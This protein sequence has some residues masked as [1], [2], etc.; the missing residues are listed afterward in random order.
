MQ[1]HHLGHHV[2]A[3]YRA[4][5]VASHIEGHYGCDVRG[6]PLA[7][8][9]RGTVAARR[10]DMQNLARG[11]SG[12]GGREKANRKSTERVPRNDR[13]RN[14]CGLALPT[15]SSTGRSPRWSPYAR[16]ARTHSEAQVEQIAASMRECG[17]TNP[18]LVDERRRDHRRAWP[19]A[20]GA[21][22]RADRVPVIGSRRLTEAQKRAY[23]LADNK[24]AEQRRLGRRAAGV[25]LAELSELGFDLR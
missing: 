13:S 14:D 7:P 5:K 6:Y 24:L 4:G 21:E 16:N 22:A 20:G 12:T 25:E 2:A 8:A 3:R 1:P 10:G 15:R 18:V 11:R 17:W 23:V 9:N 19:G